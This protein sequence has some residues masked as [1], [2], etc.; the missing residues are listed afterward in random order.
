MTAATHGHVV[1]L[2]K[3]GGGS[4]T[5]KILT[6]KDKSPSVNGTDHADGQGTVQFSHSYYN[7]FLCG[8]VMQLLGT[9]ASLVGATNAEAAREPLAK[10]ALIY[11]IYLYLKNIRDKR[12]V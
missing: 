2:I 8:I 10:S 5:L 1:D 3:K 6:V 7:I 12:G 11:L 4:V 9:R